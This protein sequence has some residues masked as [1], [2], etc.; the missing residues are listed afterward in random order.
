MFLNLHSPQEPS[1]G[2]EALN[3]RFTA[4]HEEVLAKFASLGE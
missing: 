4:V 2:Q 3:A 1:E